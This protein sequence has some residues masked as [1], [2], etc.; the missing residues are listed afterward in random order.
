[1]SMETEIDNRSNNNISQHPRVDPIGEIGVVE[2][3]VSNTG[4]VGSCALSS[5]PHV[6]GEGDLLS[7]GLTQDIAHR[8]LPMYHRTYVDGFVQGVDATL[9]I[10]M[11]TVSS[12]V[13][14]R[15]FREISKEDHP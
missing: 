2:P 7:R 6:A 13:S 12:I 14:H 10:D 1:M 11:G 4:L 5:I 8:E 3:F 9:T 15:L